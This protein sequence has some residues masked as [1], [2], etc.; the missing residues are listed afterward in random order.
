MRVSQYKVGTKRFIAFV[1]HNEIPVYPCP[2]AFLYQYFLND[3]YSTKLRVAYELTTVLSYFYSLGIN[4]EQRVS[5]GAYL[6]NAEIGRFC[7]MMKLRK[8]S[9]L[10]QRRKI[11]SS[12]VESKTI[13]NAISEIEHNTNRVKLST[14]TGRICTLRKYITF[15]YEY[16]RNSNGG[17]IL[18]NESFSFTISQLKRREKYPA[19]HEV[20][21][22]VAM[23]E[24]SI[25]PEVAQKL[26]YIIRPD[27][28][29]NPFKGSQIRNYLILTLMKEGGLRRSEICKLKISDCQFW[30][31][32]NKVRIYSNSND[33]TD[34]RQNRPNNKNGRAHISGISPSLMKGIYFY[35]KH[36]RAQ[37]LKAREHDFIFVAEKN[38]RNSAGQPITREVINYICSKLSKALNYKIH[39][40]LLRYYWNEDYS[41]KAE[42]KGIEREYAEDSRRNAM[43]W[44]PQSQMGRKYNQKYEHDRAIAIM[45]DHQESVDG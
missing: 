36:I 42:E 10:I 5:T 38:S 16:F 14:T 45:F 44:S 7:G 27:C 32:F 1:G 26:F 41:L 8:S 9:F 30:G 19:E 23:L 37:F 40:H 43:G 4:L 39:P 12:T 13:R 21:Y 2:N 28:E 17:D 31:D 34:P 24:S 25:P 33:P 3:S 11:L 15:L 18:R 29:V 6:T 20:I 22:P 35:I